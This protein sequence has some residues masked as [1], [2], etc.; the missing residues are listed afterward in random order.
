MAEGVTPAALSETFAEYV[1]LA[2]ALQAK[3]ADSIEILVGGETESI[4][5]AVAQLIWRG[6]PTG[7]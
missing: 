1:K 7:W 4:Y 5:G 6:S 2:R 3:Y